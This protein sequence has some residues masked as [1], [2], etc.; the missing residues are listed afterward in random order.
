MTGPD[1]IQ[2][3]QNGNAARMHRASGRAF[4]T[5]ASLDE[6]RAASALL[7]ALLA[8]RMAFCR[9]LRDSAAL[10]RH[11]HILGDGRRQ[12]SSRRLA[13][14]LRGSL[15]AAAIAPTAVHA[16]AFVG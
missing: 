1:R 10:L 15:L 5:E 6:T 2:T 11:R 14:S 4:Q 3:K 16:T 9:R 12:R 7:L 8:R 13:R